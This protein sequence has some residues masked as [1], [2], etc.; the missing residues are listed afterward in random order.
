MISIQQFK[1]KFLKFWQIELVRC[2]EREQELASIPK[3]TPSALNQQLYLDKQLHERALVL[4]QDYKLDKA[5]SK[6][7]TSLKVMVLLILIVALVLGVGL[8]KVVD[9]NAARELSLPWVLSALLGLHLLMYFI[10]LFFLFVKKED[11]SLIGGV[12]RQG[13]NWLNPTPE[14]KYVIQS[15]L[16]TLG[17]YRLGQFLIALIT[18][19]YWFLLLLASALTLSLL[20]L[21]QSYTFTWETTLLDLPAMERLSEFLGRSL[22]WLGVNL[23]KVSALPNAGPEI[24]AQVGRWLILMLVVYGCGVRLVTLLVL[25]G[26]LAFRMQ[27]LEVDKTQPGLSNLVPFLLRSKA[28]SID[29]DKGKLEYAAKHL[30]PTSGQGHYWLQ[31]E[32]AHPVAEFLTQDYQA[33]GVVAT[34]ADLDRLTAKFK[35][36]PAASILV[37]I[38]NRL[39]PDRGNLRLIRKLLPLVANLHCCLVHPDAAFTSAWL[40]TLEQLITEQ[41]LEQKVHLLQPE[42]KNEQ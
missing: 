41:G 17:H 4:L 2:Y 19:L 3:I 24:Q 33:L 16:H 32:H 37:A 42:D 21:F 25:V 34:L 29:K 15:F 8:A 20:F 38:D 1:S 7:I 6:S 9:S 13:M 23:P 35:L 40:A 18:H 14:A 5:L 36:Q 11:S 39:T 27:A 31:L 26:S 12:I 28:E 30:Q 22:N 10:W